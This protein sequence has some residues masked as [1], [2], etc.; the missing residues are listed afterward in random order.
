[1]DIERI[2][3]M[4]RNVSRHTGVPLERVLEIFNEALQAVV[5]SGDHDPEVLST[6]LSGPG[7]L[8]LV[9]ETEGLEDADG[10]RDFGCGHADFDA[11]FMSDALIQGDMPLSPQVQEVGMLVL[12]S[13]Q[14]QVCDPTSGAGPL[15]GEVAPGS[16]PVHVS[17]LMGRVAAAKVTFQEGDVTRWEMAH[18]HEQDPF[19]LSSNQFFGHGVDS[20]RSCFC[21]ATL[22]LEQHDLYASGFVGL[23]QNIELNDTDG[24]N[25]VIFDSGWGDGMYPSYWGMGEDGK[26]L[27]LVTDFQIAV[28]PLYNVYQ[29][30]G[31]VGQPLGE[32]VEI[33]TP[34]GPIALTVAEIE[35]DGTEGY[36][37]GIS[38]QQIGGEEFALV[39]VEGQ[40][41]PCSTTGT[42]TGDD[43]IEGFL[44]DEAPEQPLTLRLKRSIGLLPYLRL[45][46]L[47]EQGREAMS[48]LQAELLNDLPGDF[49]RMLSLALKLDLASLSQ[50]RL[51][52]F[53][54]GLSFH[55]A[56]GELFHALAKHAFLHDEERGAGALLWAA[57]YCSPNDPFIGLANKMMSLA[58][59]MHAEPAQAHQMSSIARGVCL[60]PR[61]G[62]THP[63]VT[64]VYLDGEVEKHT[65]FLKGLPEDM[66]TLSPSWERITVHEGL[67]LQFLSSP[68][69]KTYHQLDLNARV[70]DG[71]SLEQVDLR[72]ARF[73]LSTFHEMRIRACDVSFGNLVKTTFERC[74]FEDCRLSGADFSDAAVE[75]GQWKK[76]LAAGVDLERAR[77]EG[78]HFVDCD[79]S[80][81]SFVETSFVKCTFERCTLAGSQG[82]GAVFEECDYIE[83]T[84]F[85]S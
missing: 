21:D 76:C 10:I 75:G 61:P 6:L 13:G 46:G 55:P 63:P 18:R 7:M 47:E 33:D 85:S 60:A 67:E 20:G 53:V 24:S 83:T 43:V 84:P 31:F 44:L 4:A 73:G 17:V 29:I 54:E 35:S 36:K 39:D 34:D 50:A 69:P 8:S 51:R 3:K 66:G 37:W 5:K 15:V 26:R 81:A 19:E 82:E 52:R 58:E 40:E 16:Y 14:L 30:D 28:S 41:V 71:L 48:A 79:L 72:L 12:T 77:F 23:Y 80:D 56:S 42:Y 68:L 32:A 27:C 59:V 45:D 11:L 62:D 64:Q 22:S 49:D 65:D 25:V 1:M 38:Y 2:K 74:V 57:E 9:M 78:V 70:L